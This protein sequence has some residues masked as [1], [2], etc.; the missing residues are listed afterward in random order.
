M[1][2]G[3]AALDAVITYFNERLLI[4]FAIQIYGDLMVIECTFSGATNRY[5]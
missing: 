3:R 5:C 4:A 2:I 1:G